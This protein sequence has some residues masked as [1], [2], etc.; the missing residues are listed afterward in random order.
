[1]SESSDNDRKKNKESTNIKS[2]EQYPVI[3]ELGISFIPDLNNSDI[4]PNLWSR[5]LNRMMAIMPPDSDDI[6]ITSPDFITIS[7]AKSVKEI[8]EMLDI[9]SKQ[10]KYSKPQII[11][12]LIKHDYNTENVIKDYNSLIEHRKMLINIFLKENE[13]FNKDEH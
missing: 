12:E 5:R 13:D 7:K 11:R 4:Y 8:Q 9:V 10:T 1:M 6:D 2:I 3:D